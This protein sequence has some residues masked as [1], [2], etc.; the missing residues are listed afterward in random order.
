MSA[1]EPGY[2]DCCCGACCLLGFVFMCRYCV[3]AYVYALVFCV[4]LTDHKK[5]KEK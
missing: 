3:D 1:R 5:K 2:L 4:K